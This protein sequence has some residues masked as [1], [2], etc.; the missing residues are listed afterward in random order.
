MTI[1]WKKFGNFSF[2]VPSRKKITDNTWFLFQLSDQK[3]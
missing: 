2:R 1:S 3:T